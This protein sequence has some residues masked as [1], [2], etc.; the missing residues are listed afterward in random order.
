M[1]S[2]VL[3]VYNQHVLLYIGTL[4][5]ISKNTGT[6]QLMSWK[7]EKLQR[8]KSKKISLHESMLAFVVGP[9]K[10]TCCI[11]FDRTGA[12]FKQAKDVPISHHHPYVDRNP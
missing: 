1:D 9:D 6:K 5:L 10:K 2:S 12:S 7:V 3:P 8:L 11:L 4:R